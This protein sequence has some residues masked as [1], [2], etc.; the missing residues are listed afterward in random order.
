MTDRDYD[1]EAA[2]EDE[3]PTP[4]P[5]GIVTK[6][7]NLVP[8]AT[9]QAFA[10]KERTDESRQFDDPFKTLG[11][12][13]GLIKPPF[14]PAVIAELP[15]LNT[16]HARATKTKA[17]DTV[18]A[19]WTFVPASTE[20]EGDT[21]P[22][23]MT[24]FATG[25]RESLTTVLV[26]AQ[27]DYETIGWGGL[28]LVRQDHKFDADIVDINHVP[29][30]TM[31][32]HKTRQAIAQ[33]RGRKMVWFKYRNMAPSPW[34][35]GYDADEDWEVHKDSGEIS[36]GAGSLEADVRGSEILF[37]RNYWTGED[38]YG[39]PDVIPAMGAMVGDV[40]RRNYNQAFFENHGVPAF[41]VY[42]TGD[43]EMGN[44][45][46]ETGK[47]DLEEAVDSALKEVQANPH[48]VMTLFIPSR[49]DARQDVKVDIKPLAVEIKDASFQMYRQD[50]RDEVLSAHGVPV[51]RLGIVE[52]GSLGQN[53]AEQTDNIY[54]ES[55]IDPRQENLEDL[56]NSYVIADFDGWEGWK[57][58][59]VEV[60]VS[61]EAEELDILTTLFEHAAVTP[62]QLL[63]RYADRFG[64]TVPVP[65]HPAME[66]YYL[67]GQPL[68]GPGDS[69]V[70]EVEGVLKS[71]VDDLTEWS[72]KGELDGESAADRR[73]EGARFAQ[74]LEVARRRLAPSRVGGNGGTSGSADGDKSGGSGAA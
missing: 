43:F 1:Q 64:L 56:I 67:G 42:V 73:F 61:N 37:W 59:L 39:F 27:L 71:L 18:G 28:E 31:R 20:T 38:F 58:Q 36:E 41:A 74:S 45:N 15:K 72:V 11:A 32:V 16:Y 50:N 70:E 6:A 34:E 7:G 63:K 65:P 9:V 8:W 19:G 3:S 53:V 26:R 12:Q 52:A 30:H 10:V 29:A 24:D 33:A 4:E 44:E 13:K 68:T 49:A 55:V 57:F 40:S 48:S 54:K 66:Q 5:F 35:E 51:Y 21:A 22:E 17:Q 2:D 47:T 23:E 60:D 69:M 14:N 25:I 62:L 46:E